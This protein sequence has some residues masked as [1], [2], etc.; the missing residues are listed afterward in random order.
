MSPTCRAAT[1]ARKVLQVA[2][3]FRSS[4]KSTAPSSPK[5]PSPEVGAFVSGKSWHFGGRDS[6]SQKNVFDCCKWYTFSSTGRSAHDLRPVPIRFRPLFDLPIALLQVLHN[7]ARPQRRWRTR[8][9]HSL[10][11][12]PNA[13]KLE[14]TLASAAVSA[15][16]DTSSTPL[17]PLRRLAQ[18][19]D[20]PRPA[21]TT[22]NIISA[23]MRGLSRRHGAEPP[24]SASSAKGN[25]SNALAD[26]DYSYF[27]LESLSF[28]ALP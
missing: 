15:A 5:S 22:T 12:A 11:S 13:V 7:R 2:R 14:R 10:I 18:L 6:R 8:T 25:G 23:N 27:V 9:V 24:E 26:Q 4:P 20:N 28:E 1:T 21:S 3:S 16:A 19:P 17:G